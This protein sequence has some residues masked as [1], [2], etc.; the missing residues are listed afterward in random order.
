MADVQLAVIDQQN[1]EIVAAVPGIQGI[2]GP[3]VPAG[4][5]QNQLLVKQ[6]GVDYDTAWSD[7]I[8]ILGT[9]DVTGDA[10]F[11][12]DVTIQSDLTV[13]RVGIGTLS[14]AALLNVAS[15]D[16][17]TAPSADADEVLIEGTGNTGISLF[18]GLNSK[19]NIYFGENT[20]GISRGAIVYDTSDDSLAF[21][22]NGLAN[23]R[24]RIDSSGRLLVGT[25]SAL[26]VGG[27]AGF[28][29]FQIAGLGASLVRF[30]NSAS[31]PVLTFAK[32][33][34][35]TTGA[36]TVVNSG[37]AIGQIF[38]SGAD[39]TGYVPA[40]L[41]ETRVDGTPGADD[42]P[43][44]LVFSVT[45][46]G[47]SSPTEAMRIKNTRVINFSNA[48]VYADNAAAKTGGLVDGDVYRT[49]TGDLKIVYT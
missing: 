15:A 9:L 41:I 27:S 20:V 17:S 21:S 35:T 36:N 16:T 31:S 42:M 34:S 29:P 47:A 3:G 43:G 5:T 33:R 44:R 46:D 19:A 10:T 24:A 30:A 49:S 13:G 8:D 4:G 6:S 14:P 28:E 2:A 37:D 39:G 18:C 1:I 38:F 12:Q 23:E 11:D 45:A 40:A 48:P 22:T 25:S 32:S 7:D 26:N